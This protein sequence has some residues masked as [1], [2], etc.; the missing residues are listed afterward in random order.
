MINIHHRLVEEKYVYSRASE[1]DLG[2]C[3]GASMYRPLDR[4]RLLLQVRHSVI[5]VYDN[6]IVVSLYAYLMCKNE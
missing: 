4:V 6:I 3:P 5:V 2:L 1:A